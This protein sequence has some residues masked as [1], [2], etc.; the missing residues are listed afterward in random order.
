MTSMFSSIKVNIDSDYCLAKV[1]ASM[2]TYMIPRHACIILL[3]YFRCIVTLQRKHAES[4]T[5]QERNNIMMTC[6]YFKHFIC[7]T[8]MHHQ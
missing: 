8:V 4:G 2:V 6:K 1:L 3:Y 7:Y 5:E